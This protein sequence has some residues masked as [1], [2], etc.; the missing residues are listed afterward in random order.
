MKTILS[1]IFSLIALLPAAAQGE[2]GSGTIGSRD[3]I[4]IRVFR[5]DDLT[6]RGQLSASGTIDMPLIGTVKVAGMSTDAAANL[7]E[8]KLRDGYLVRP[9]VTVSITA[10]VRKTVTVLGEA[11]KPGLFRLDPNRKLTLVEAIGLAGGVT[12]IGNAKK[13]T[14]K[15]RNLENPI[16]IDLR[17][18][19][20][21]KAKDIPLQDGDIITI[22]ESLF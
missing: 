7:I 4:E 8:R 18:I 19:T 17:A 3:S 13:I 10:R 21:G 2:R 16:R 9:E 20:A 5:E 6:T 11:Q 12:R 1:I 15:R 14:L 22:P